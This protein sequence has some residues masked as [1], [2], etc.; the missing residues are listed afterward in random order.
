[1][2]VSLRPA[3]N[4]KLNIKLYVYK[5]LSMN[6]YIDKILKTKNHYIK[7]KNWTIKTMVIVHRVAC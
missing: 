2:H 3:L 7:S 1:M 6:E 5:F 4:P